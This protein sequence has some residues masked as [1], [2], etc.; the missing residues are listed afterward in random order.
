MQL[1]DEVSPQKC[2]GVKLHNEQGSQMGL[3]VKWG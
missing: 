1:M 3:S 2:E